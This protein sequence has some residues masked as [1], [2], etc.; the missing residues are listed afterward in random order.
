MHPYLFVLIFGLILCTDGNSDTENENMEELGKLISNLIRNTY[1]YK[2]SKCRFKKLSNTLYCGGH[3]EDVN[4]KIKI[5]IDFEMKSTFPQFVEEGF[6][7]G[8]T[9]KP[10][11]YE[12]Y[13]DEEKKIRN[14]IHWVLKGLIPRYGNYVIILFLWMILICFMGF[15]FNG[16]RCFIFKKLFFLKKKEP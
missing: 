6:Y 9:G 11:D 14:I 13:F 12:L 7:Y 15:F 8:D 4:F 16:C 5:L 1:P 2:T 10:W 3:W